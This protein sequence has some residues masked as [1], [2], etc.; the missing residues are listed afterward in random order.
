MSLHSRTRLARA[1]AWRLLAQPRSVFLRFRWPGLVSFWA[2]LAGLALLAVVPLAGPRPPTRP[3]QLWSASLTPPR[4]DSSLA[5]PAAADLG[6]GHQPLSEALS[7]AAHTAPTPPVAQPVARDLAPPPTL[8]S[9]RPLE[10]TPY[11]RTEPAD[12][13]EPSHRATAI[14]A[15]DVHVD[16]DQRTPVTSDRLGPLTPRQPSDADASGT[17]TPDRRVGAHQSTLGNRA[18]ADA[19]FTPVG[20]GGGGGQL[21]AGAA[22]GAPTRGEHRQPGGSTGSRSGSSAAALAPDAHPAPAAGA[23]VAAPRGIA[24]TSQAANWWRPAVSRVIVH[25]PGERTI[26]A[27]PGGAPSP[28]RGPPQAPVPSLRRDRG[29]GGSQGV[30]DAQSAAPGTPAPEVGR[31]RVAPPGTADPAE[32]LR[33]A[34]GFGP[35][36]RDQLG[37]RPEWAGTL[38]RSGQPD[39]SP[40]SA[41]SDVPV[42]WT[43]AIATR[44]TGLGRWVE[45]TEQ[46]VVSRWRSEDLG[47]DLR[48]MGIGGDVTLWVIVRPSGR[49]EAVQVERS[50]GN[51]VLDEL[52]VHAVPTRL[53]RLPRTHRSGLHHRL[54]LRYRNPLLPTAMRNP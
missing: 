41:L 36:D 34:L 20:G 43:T 46:I 48:A 3:V 50:S 37:P 25:R 47:V 12:A 45:R 17:P 18:H 21:G 28:V 40:Q 27:A 14:S 5:V 53:P 6:D 7:A 26:A 11:V 10:W 54:T 51:A 15:R 24:P 39:R 31:R 44:G 32:D 22:A 35:V 33:E 30:A 8:S 29:A 52:A 23:P 9:E 49:V 4:G 19:A 38:W 1:L 16:R 2:H 42:A 13:T